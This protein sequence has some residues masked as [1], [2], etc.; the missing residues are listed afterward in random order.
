MTHA[1][2]QIRDAAVVAI[3]G[4]TTTGDNVFDSRYHPLDTTQLPA[5]VVSYSEDGTEEVEQVSG[6]LQQR[7][8]ELVFV[9][10]AS[11]I[12]GESLTDSLDL[13]AEELEVALAGGISGTKATYL[14]S[15]E[16]EFETDEELDGAIGSVLVSYVCIYDTTAGVPGTLE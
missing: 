16:F 1:R 13:M 7:Q 9:G 6:G 4:L 10:V 5:W 11:E 2:K 14:V 3:G 15:T 8:L 12:S